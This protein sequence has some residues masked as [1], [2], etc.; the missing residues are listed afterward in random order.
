[1]YVGM[2]AISSDSVKCYHTFV[3]RR[4]FQSLDISLNVTRV[5]NRASFNARPTF[6]DSVLQ[7]LPIISDFL[8]N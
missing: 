4:R 7:Y 2:L 6:R 8:H 3:R 1:M 5:I